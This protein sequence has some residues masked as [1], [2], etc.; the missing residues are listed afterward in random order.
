LGLTPVRRTARFYFW[1][2][3]YLRS[4]CKNNRTATK[5]QFLYFDET[6]HTHI[7]L[8]WIMHPK[9]SLLMVPLT[10]LT[11][12]HKLVLVVIQLT[13]LAPSLVANKCQSNAEITLEN[14][15]FAATRGHLSGQ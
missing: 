8:S 7:H 12:F 11:S 2:Y 10:G 1:P 5:A 6:T 14:H 3:D 15:F 9:L 13:S 4:T